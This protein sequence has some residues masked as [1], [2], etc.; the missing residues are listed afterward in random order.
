MTEF[1]NIPRTIEDPNYRYKM[2]LLQQRI[3]GKGMNIH[4]TLLNLKDVAKFLR[5][6]HEYILKFFA[7]ELGVQTNEK[8]S[9]IWINGEISQL[10]VQKV[11]DKFI[12]KFILCS[13]CKLPEMYLEVTE[14]DKEKQVLGKG[15]QSKN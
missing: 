1:V 5:I 6:S 3:E 12:D 7:Y 9:D 4:T 15:G 11:L 2:P 14:G 8:N 10:D 13:N